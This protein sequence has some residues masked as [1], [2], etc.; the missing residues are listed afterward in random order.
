MIL[1]LDRNDTA[2]DVS[3]F[4]HI[5]GAMVLVGA[6]LLAAVALA[7]DNKSLRLG[8]RALLV[9]ALPGYIVMRVAAQIVLGEYPSDDEGWIGMG[10]ATSELGLLLMIVATVCANRA[11]KRD[12]PD[13]GLAKAAFGIS[14]FLVVLYVVTIWAMTAKPS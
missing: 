9:G 13:S 14:A 8:Y 6:L 1:A 11:M 2:W 3:L 4:F 10:F 12:A 7:G 5:A